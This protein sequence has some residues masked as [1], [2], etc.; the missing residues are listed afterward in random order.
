[1]K[2]FKTLGLV[3]LIAA[4]IVSFSI[5][6]FAQDKTKEKKETAKTT[7]VQKASPDKPDCS[8]CP[9]AVKAKCPE[10]KD[11]KVFIKNVKEAA[12]LKAD[13]KCKEECKTKC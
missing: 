13:E 9:S 8:K 5:Y 4:L 10:A 3:L 12:G 2:S 1:M 7:Q 11:G 6:A